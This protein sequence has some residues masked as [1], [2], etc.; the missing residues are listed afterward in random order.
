[1]LVSL[2]ALEVGMKLGAWEDCWQ[3]SA[4]SGALIV[5][6]FT[7]C[8]A[9]NTMRSNIRTRVSHRGLMEISRLSWPHGLMAH[10][11]GL[12]ASWLLPTLCASHTASF[13][14]SRGLGCLRDACC[15][16][17]CA[18]RFQGRHVFWAVCC[19]KLQV[20]RPR[21]QS[22]VLVMHAVWCILQVLGPRR[23]PVDDSYEAPPRR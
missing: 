21:C 13:A 22:V 20:P 14:T 3:L 9:S 15:S 12:M 18:C 19:S 1:M 8:S 5:V 2:A 11:L 10:G 23:Q 7:V 4:A 16:F 17:L 6:V